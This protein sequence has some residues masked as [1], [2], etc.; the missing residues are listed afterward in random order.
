MSRKNLWS[1]RCFV[2]LQIQEVLP[3]PRTY[4]TQLRVSSA[5]GRHADVYLF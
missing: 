4:G 5:H 3:Q 2:L 1:G